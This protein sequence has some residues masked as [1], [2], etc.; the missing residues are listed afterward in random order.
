MA[1]SA[2]TP[3]DENT[4][5]WTPVEE[6][7][8]AQSQPQPGI[9][10]REIPLDSYT[11]ATE[12]GLQSIGRGV[13]DAIKGTWSSLAAPPQDKTEKVVSALSPAALPL[14]RT[15]RGIGHTAEDATQIVGAIHDINS[16]ADP[17]GTYLKVAQE[18]A[19][20]G[21]GQALTALATEGAGRAVPAVAKAIPSARNVLRAAGKVATGVGES[22]DPDLVG[23]ISPRGAH[24]LRVAQKAGKIA[25]KLT[26]EAPAEAAAELDATG[27]NRD[28]AGE[29]ARKPAKELDATSENKP[30]AGGM[31]EHTGARPAPKAAPRAATAQPLQQSAALGKIPPRTIVLDPATGAPEFSDVIAARQQVAAA[32]PPEATAPPA[33][34]PILERLRQYASQPEEAAVPAPE[35]DLT[36]LL[37]KS[38]DAVR[39]RKMAARPAAEAPQPVATNASGESAA[40]QEAINRVASEKAQ[41][42]KRYRIDTRSGQEIPL[43]GADAVD[44]VAG[45]Y[46]VIVAR[47]PKGETVLDQG[48]R[49]RPYRAKGTAR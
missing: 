16:S 41:G 33:A 24:A 17:T 20:Q 5:Q 35:E 11:H 43:F 27:E 26:E 47:S 22:L 7:H 21:A 1:A 18:T 14:Y 42:L 8:A 19:G 44:A 2:W 49:A 46:D 29:P 32:A 4:A 36:D 28:Y 37:Q 39:A 15:L 48:V 13:R 31:D 38:L 34:D 30:F 6:A 40:S 3:V 25:S 9:L 23:V 10:D 12:S 45:P